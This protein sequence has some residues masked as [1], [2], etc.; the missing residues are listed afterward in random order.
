M[1]KILI[2]NGPN[3]NLLG[4]RE[5]EI[6]GNTTF[7]AFFEQLNH[8]FSEKVTLAYLQSNHEGAL[9]DAL[10]EIGFDEQYLGVVFNA[11]AYTH[12]SIALRD[13]IAAIKVPVVEVHISNVHA[14]EAFR[15]H[16]FIAPVCVGSIVGLGLKGYELA[17]EF[18]LEK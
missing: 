6:Y 1:K 13:A 15:H 14:R 17:I 8:A 16:S 3:L 12:T 4:K 10:H 11:G 18:L 9:L 2:L 5:P 7:L